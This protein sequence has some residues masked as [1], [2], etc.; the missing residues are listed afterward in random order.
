MSVR[1]KNIDDTL[2]G[3]AHIQVTANSLNFKKNPRYGVEFWHTCAAESARERWAP[4]VYVS[5]SS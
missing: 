3:V 5:L 2:N 4:T 1:V